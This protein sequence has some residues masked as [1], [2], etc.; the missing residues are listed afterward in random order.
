MPAM[1]PAS[2]SLHIAADIAGLAAAAVAA[3]AAGVTFKFTSEVL[4]G[5]C[6]AV[7]EMTGAERAKPEEDDESE[8]SGW[9]ERVRRCSGGGESSMWQRV[10]VHTGLSKIAGPCSTWYVGRN[11]G[12]P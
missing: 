1:I 8:S 6:S 4:M 7:Q 2:D 12:Q 5:L 3:T 11:F 10:C 9:R